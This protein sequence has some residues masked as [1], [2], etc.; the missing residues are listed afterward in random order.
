MQDRDELRLVFWEQLDIYCDISNTFPSCVLKEEQDFQDFPDLKFVIDG[1]PYFL[2]R[3]SY[4]VYQGSGVYVLLI[5]SDQNT[6]EW[7]LGLNFHENYYSIY[8]Q[9]NRQI[10]L[11]LSKTCQERLLSLHYPPETIISG[12][13]SLL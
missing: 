8:D 1:Q 9:E 12:E 11:A 10:A 7:I 2:P 13:Q 3:E 6:Q 5:M 4:V